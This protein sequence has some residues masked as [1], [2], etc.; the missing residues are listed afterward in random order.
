MERDQLI[1]ASRAGG[2]GGFHR[3]KKEGRKSQKTLFS[4][5]EGEQQRGKGG[6]HEDSE[7]GKL[8]LEKPLRHLGGGGGG[9][10]PRNIE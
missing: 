6:G 7:K 9:A 1:H 2:V 4:T 5:C 3:E 8:C 10:A